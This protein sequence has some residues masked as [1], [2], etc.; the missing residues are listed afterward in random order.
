[1]ELIRVGGG[2]NNKGAGSSPELVEENKRLKKKIGM[3][4]D[5]IATK[6][7]IIRTLDSGSSGK[8]NTQD[9]EAI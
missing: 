1:L 8:K 2:Y 3:L 4:E 6:E 5:E 7:A 9:L